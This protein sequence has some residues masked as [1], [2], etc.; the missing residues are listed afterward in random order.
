M[1]TPH[2]M[3][4]KSNQNL[5]PLIFTKTNMNA[6]AERSLTTPKMPVRKREA[7]MEGKPE[8]M[9][10]VGASGQDEDNMS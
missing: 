1:D 7:E 2:R 3:L 5:L 9:K 8:V 10:M 6:M 4:P